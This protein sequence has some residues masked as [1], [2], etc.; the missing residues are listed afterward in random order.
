MERAGGGITLPPV[1]L[2]SSAEQ[3]QLATARHP[4]LA[5][6]EGDQ[7]AASG[8]NLGDGADLGAVEPTGR[9]PNLVTDPEGAGLPGIGILTLL[10]Q[11]CQCILVLVELAPHFQDALTQRNEVGVEAASSD[12]SIQTSGD[13]GAHQPQILAGI[14][15]LRDPAGVFDGEAGRRGV[16]GAD[17]ADLTWASPR[18]VLDLISYPELP[19]LLVGIF[20]IL[21][22]SL[23][24]GIG[25]F[26][27]ALQGDDL[28][29]K[30]DKGAEIL[31]H[32]EAPLFVGT[33][34]IAQ[35]PSMG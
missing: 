11:P 4:N 6:G 10:E 7:E 29:A 24:L 21:Q 26:E 18:G 25:Q 31:T 19:T 32:F 3:L 22:Q 27:L 35:A 2:G 20:P 33:G 12:G 28:G 15:R 34:I 5:T 17:L 1:K 16:D 8:R 23:L 14:G 9:H 30:G 13:G